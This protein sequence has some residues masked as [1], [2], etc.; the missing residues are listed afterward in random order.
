MIASTDPEV[1]TFPDLKELSNAAAV[2]FRSLAITAISEGGRFTAALSGGN[3]P[4]ELY[5]LLAKR[6]YSDRIAWEHVHL[7]WADERCVPPGH[8]ESNFRLVQEQ[9]LSG[10]SIPPKNIHRIKGERGAVQAAK[11]YEQHL[12]EFFGGNG[13]PVL[14][15]VILGV[16]ADGHT[17][18]LFPGLRHVD[19][20]DR[21]V[22]PVSPGYQRKDRVTLALPVLNHA[23]HVL[24]LAS[25]TAKQRVIRSILGDGNPDD[26]PAGLVRPLSGACTWFLDQDA[27]AQL[28]GDKD[29][30]Q[31][32]AP[33]Q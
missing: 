4:K 16:G 32:K 13:C 12:R 7:F 18:S 6:P 19:E 22:L 23:K 9:L 15:A 27:A 14:D 1:R 24:I 21:L 30:W 3:T 33:G 17:A 5:A 10:V 11:E 31:W 25:G 2:Q 8:D 26:L 28:P 20:C 29:A